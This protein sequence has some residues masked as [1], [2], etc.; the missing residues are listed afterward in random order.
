M[1]ATARMIDSSLVFMLWWLHEVFLE[2]CLIVEPVVEVAGSYG[3]PETRY[4]YLDQLPLIFCNLGLDDFPFCIPNTPV[5]RSSSF[6]G[7]T[8]KTISMF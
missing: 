5:R 4:A 7:T 2:W 6:L 8:V 3:W 1:A